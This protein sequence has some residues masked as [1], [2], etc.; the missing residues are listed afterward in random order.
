MPYASD[1]PRNQIQ[2]AWRSAAYS[3]APKARSEREALAE[4]GLNTS[5]VI[6]EI[7][8]HLN[9]VSTS[10]QMLKYQ[11][12]QCVDSHP[13]GPTIDALDSQLRNL[14]D[15]LQELREFGRPLRLSCESF[16]LADLAAEVISQAFPDL[17]TQP[18]EFQ[19]NFPESLPPV[20]ADRKKLKQVVVNLIKNATEAMPEGGLLRLRSYE[21]AN[22]ISLEIQD[23]GIG[24]P[25]DARIFDAF[26]TSKTEGVGLGLCIAQEI[27]NAHHGTIEYVSDLGKGTIFKISL[28]AARA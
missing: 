21:E 19:Q 20:L 7:A 10:V 28:P 27:M 8:N 3:N 23:T 11:L 18:L 25:E 26:A 22:H 2:T 1:L 5:K 24:I 16:S 6:H 4:L 13:M 15:L 9:G 17:A 14:R 12:T